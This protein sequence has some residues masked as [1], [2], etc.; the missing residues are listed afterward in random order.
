MVAPTL[1][2]NVASAKASPRNTLVRNSIFEQGA[3]CIDGLCGFSGL[4]TFKHV[5]RLCEVYITMI[6]C[7]EPKQNT[8]RVVFT[9]GICERR[10][11]SKSKWERSAISKL[12]TLPNKSTKRH[13]ISPRLVPA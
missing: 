11:I 7:E 2:R 5:S 3:L 4:F 9:G 1:T 13:E 10:M 6:M 8:T 12:Y